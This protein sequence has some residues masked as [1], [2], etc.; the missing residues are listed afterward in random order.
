MEKMKTTASRLDK[1]FR[2]LHTCTAIAA[3]AALVGIAII[4]AAF[5]FRISPDVIGTGYSSIDIGFLTLNIAPQYSPDQH[6]VL[7]VVAVELVFAFVLALACRRFIDCLRSILS[8]MIQGEPFRA[9]ASRSLADLGKLSIVIG[10]V[11]N[12]AMLTSQAMTV[13][14]LN[15]PELLISEKI[16]HIRGN[17][18]ADFSFLAFSAVLFLLS[19]VFRYGQELQQLS[20]ETL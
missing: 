20:D 14:A 1:F 4:L 8:P 2:I 3:I 11:S 9:A 6:T 16:T 7:Q 12:A 17:F 5:L 10:I 13:F 19:Y 15:L 18:T